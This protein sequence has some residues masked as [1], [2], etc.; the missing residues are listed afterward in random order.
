MNGELLFGLGAYCGFDHLPA[1][2][3]PNVPADH[4]QAN[5]DHG[6]LCL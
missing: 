6:A 1:S 3:G 4:R 2:E 5:G